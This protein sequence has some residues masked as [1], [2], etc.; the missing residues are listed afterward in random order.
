[1]SLSCSCNFDGDTEGWDWWWVAPEDFT[2]FD[3]K[4]RK[5][6]HSCGFLIATGEECAKVW[7]YRHPLTDI[8]YNIVGDDVPLAPRV[9][10]SRCGEIFFNLKEYGYC[11]NIDKPMPEQLR[12]H[13][14]LS[15]FTPP[16][17]TLG[18]VAEASA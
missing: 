1:M 15:G 4:R 2:P 10:C 12:E 16:N 5:R 8:E 11:V 17:A 14:E 6:C 9:L 7:R 18:L 13:W 3:G